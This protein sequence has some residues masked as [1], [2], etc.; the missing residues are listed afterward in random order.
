MDYELK[1][2]RTIIE[3][4]RAGADLIERGGWQNMA[5]GFQEGP[6]CHC[7]VTSIVAT[8]PW[9]FELR[10]LTIEAMADKVKPGWRKDSDAIEFSTR[11]MEQAIASSAGVVVGDWNDE[12][13]S[14]KP[15]LAMMRELATKLEALI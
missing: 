5:G 8:V 11:T 3:A 7:V 9:N 6:N 14:K 13:E 15:V 4:L 2:P 1:E 10:M 12:Q